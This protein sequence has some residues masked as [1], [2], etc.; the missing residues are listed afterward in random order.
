M[1]EIFGAATVNLTQDHVI[2]VNEKDSQLT[3]RR[4]RMY[5]LLP[6]HRQI[7]PLEMGQLQTIALMEFSQ[8]LVLGAKLSWNLINDVDVFR[9]PG[10]AA[11]KDQGCGTAHV[12][13]KGPRESRSQ[14]TKELLN[15]F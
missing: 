1:V 12:Q 4:L 2:D 3:E 8:Q 7:A 11:S 14:L 15:R 9:S 5:T 10:K 6:S 13:A